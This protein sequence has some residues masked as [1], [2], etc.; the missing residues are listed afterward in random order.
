MVRARVL[1]VQKIVVIAL[2]VLFL[3][4]FQSDQLFVCIY[5]G[6]LVFI[7]PRHNADHPCAYDIDW[8]VDGGDD[9]DDFDGVAR[10]Q[11][12]Q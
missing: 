8:Y 12:T 5:Q 6:C 1:D 9:A 2:Y 3:L 7:I 11:V 10:K 4:T